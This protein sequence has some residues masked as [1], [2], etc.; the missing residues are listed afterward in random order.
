MTMKIMRHLN[1]A[2]VYVAMVRIIGSFPPKANKTGNFDDNENEN[3]F[4]VNLCVN[5]S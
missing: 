3:R 2:V 1:S 4:Y 5:S